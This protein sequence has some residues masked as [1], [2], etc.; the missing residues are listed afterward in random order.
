MLHY[1]VTSQNYPAFINVQQQVEGFAET[2]DISA[3]CG[4]KPHPLHTWLTK[5]VMKIV[6][7]ECFT[8]LSM[9]MLVSSL[10]FYFNLA[11]GVWVLLLLVSLLFSIWVSGLAGF[12][13]LQHYL[14]CQ[15]ATQDSESLLALY[16]EI[17]D[18]D[19]PQL[20]TLLGNPNHMTLVKLD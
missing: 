8:L 15:D 5:N 17:S 4:K 16:I 12:E 10:A 13:L 2:E 1:L 14:Q 19:L 18:Q 7:V 20:T 6:K 11:V 9:V 3:L